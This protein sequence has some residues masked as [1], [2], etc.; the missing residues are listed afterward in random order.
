VV[1]T[2]K[3]LNLKNAVALSQR[4]CA[5]IVAGAEEIDLSSVESVDSAA[6]AV[7]LAWQRQAQK[8][9][10]SLRLLAAPASL[11]S[12]INLYGMQD[13]FELQNTRAAQ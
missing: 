10:R 7:L 6:V 9:S 2:E 5:A 11:L 8:Q 13:F 4:G 3:E 1:L 12:L